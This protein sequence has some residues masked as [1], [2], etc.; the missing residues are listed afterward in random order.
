MYCDL[1]EGRSQFFNM[2][3]EFFKTIRL[4]PLSGYFVVAVTKNVDIA[5]TQF[6]IMTIL[7]V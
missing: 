6:Y 1:V 4:S 7:T 2:G 3:A 5:M